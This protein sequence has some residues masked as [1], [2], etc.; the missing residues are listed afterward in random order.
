MGVTPSG[1]TPGAV[2]LYLSIARF[3]QEQIETGVYPAGRKL[4][5]EHEL[6]RSFGVNRHTVHRAIEVL[7]QQGIVCLERGKGF[8]V[9]RR[10]KPCVHG[11]TATSTFTLEARRTGKTYSTQLLGVEVVDAPEQVGEHL[12]LSSGESVLR[13]RILR[14]GSDSS[15]Y[16]STSYLP[17]RRVPGLRKSLSQ[18]SSL[19]DLLQARYGFTLR[20]VWAQIGAG[21]PTDE[22]AL[23]LNIISTVPVVRLESTW[24]TEQEG[25]LIEYSETCCRADSHKYRVSFEP[26]KF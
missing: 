3:L 14:R 5:S 1:N 18:L 21:Y 15:V 17:E 9:A 13:L 22:E 11:L 10:K 20:R 8:F 7:A 25:L 6:G 19:H 2:P 12:G 26:D 24:V 16:F 23:I 4:P